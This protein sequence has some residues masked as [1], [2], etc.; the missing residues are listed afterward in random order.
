[1]KYNCQVTCSNG[2]GVMFVKH[3]P[4]FDEGLNAHHSS[5]VHSVTLAMSKELD[6]SLTFWPYAR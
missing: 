6:E 2:G 4:A 3:L 5:L 1:M